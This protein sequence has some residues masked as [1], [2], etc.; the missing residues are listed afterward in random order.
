MKSL[1][2]ASIAVGVIFGQATPDPSWGPILLN[3]GAL[4]ILGYHMLWGLPAIFK[5]MDENHS[6]LM[7]L[8][9]QGAKETRDADTAR[10]NRFAK[11]LEVMAENVGNVAQQQEA[12]IFQTGELKADVQQQ[13][14]VQ[15]LIRDIMAKRCDAEN[16]PLRQQGSLRRPLGPD[17]NP[18]AGS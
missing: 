10:A 6:T 18:N 3:G 15:K 13:T 8:V 17:E 4:A 16:C 5:K 1:F 12:T 11:A 9:L 7:A 2:F 14:R